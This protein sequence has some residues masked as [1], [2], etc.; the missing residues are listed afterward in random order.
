MS[1]DWTTKGSQRAMLHYWTGKS[2]FYRP[3]VAPVLRSSV[4]EEAPVSTSSSSRPEGLASTDAP[5]IVSGNRRERRYK[6]SLKP[7]W[8]DSASWVSMGP[9][10]RAHLLELERKK[11]APDPVAAAVA[12]GAMLASSA[13]EGELRVAKKSQSKK[14]KT[15][16]IQKFKIIDDTSGDLYIDTVN[17]ND[18]SRM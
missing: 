17:E 3:D 1:D 4:V 9:K 7:D 11:S 15:V 2:T 12:G 10:V 6:G 14:N 13:S 5:V 18:Q 8:C 16:F